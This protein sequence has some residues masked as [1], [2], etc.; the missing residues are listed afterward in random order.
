MSGPICCPNVESS[1]IKLSSVGVEMKAVSQPSQLCFA[2][3]S[4]SLQT[5]SLLA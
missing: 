3:L 5:K 2:S 1:L 4:A